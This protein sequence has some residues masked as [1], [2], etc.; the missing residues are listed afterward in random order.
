[1]VCLAFDF[2]GEWRP[3]SPKTRKK[4]KKKKKKKKDMTF[5]VLSGPLNSKP[6]NLIHLKVNSLFQNICC[7]LRIKVQIMYYK[8]LLCG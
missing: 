8:K 3:D 7:A 1:M 4:K 6:T 2:V 5:K